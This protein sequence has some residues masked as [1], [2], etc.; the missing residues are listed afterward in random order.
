[1]LER[2]GLSS[3]LLLAAAALLAHCAAARRGAAAEGPYQTDV[4]LSGKDGYHTFRIPA[5]IVTPKGTLLAFCEGRKG[6]RS[7]HGDIDLVLRRSRDGGTTWGPL[8]LVHEEG[9]TRKITIGNPCPVVDQSTGTLWLSFC[10]NN[11]D[12]FVTHSTDDGRTWAKPRKITKD[13]KKPGWTWYATGPGVGIQLERGPHKGRLLIPCDHR[14]KRTGGTMYSHV[15]FSDDHGTTWR[16]GGMLAKHTDECQVVEAADGSLL[17]NMRSY[18][19][20]AAKVKEREGLRA[21]ARS[22]DGGQTWSELWFD[23]ALIEPV[24]QAS[25]LRYTWAET[26]GRSRL[27]FSNPAS[28][29]TRH[30]MTVRLSYDEGKTWP[31]SKLIHAG[32]AAYSCLAVLPDGRIG[33]LYERDGYKKITFARFSLE[34]LTDGEDTL[35]AKRRPRG[36]SGGGS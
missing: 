34:W 26:G 5:L 24:C 1:M 4:F 30:R 31:V 15:F 17:L 35:K 29:T 3:G 13:V 8:E 7:D 21:V 12:V 32:S 22:R 18:W 25:F 9:G 36:K 28:K 27:L 16:L 11:N 10:R 19:W 20:R 6:G 23:A 2:C 14:E 33:L